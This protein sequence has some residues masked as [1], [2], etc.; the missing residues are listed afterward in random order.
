MKMIFKIFKRIKYYLKVRNKKKVH[1]LHIGKTGGTAIKDALKSNLITQKYVIKLHSHDTTLHD[2]P[3]GEKV[4]FFVRDPISRFVSGF[5]SRKRKGRPRFN[6]EWSPDEKIAFEYFN[7]PNELAEALSSKDQIKRKLA[8]KSMNSIYHVKS[9]YWDWFGNK[10][11]FLS[12]L[13][14]ILFIG[15]QENMEEDFKSLLSKLK[16]NININ[17]PNDDIKAHKNP[18]NIDTTISTSSEKNLRKWYKEDFEFINLCIQSKN[19]L[20]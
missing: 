14:D 3:E 7:T 20:L 17:L 2:I 8:Q 1:F 12:R 13:D 11:Y 6:N 18:K 15:T 5:Y 4:F 10:D 9:S 16:Y 19:N